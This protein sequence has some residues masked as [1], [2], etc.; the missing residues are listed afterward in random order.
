MWIYTESVIKFQYHIMYDVF[1]YCV[2]V[3]ALIRFAFYLFCIPSEMDG[4]IPML[5]KNMQLCKLRDGLCGWVRGW[6]GR[7][8]Y[9]DPNDGIMAM[10]N[11]SIISLFGF[12]FNFD[13][14]K[15]HAREWRKRVLVCVYKQ[16]DIEFL[17]C[18][19]IVCSYNV[20]WYEDAFGKIVCWLCAPIQ[21]HH[22]T[23]CN[24]NNSKAQPTTLYYYD[25]RII[26][27]HTKSTHAP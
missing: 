20:K 1:G 27:V 2:L 19:Y 25:F 13:A 4:C 24:M 3:H 21:S 14:T 10:N 23:Q 8:V 12:I 16:I 17:C 7:C 6:V 26:Q 22:L 9:M 11:F 18:W 5:H 15:E